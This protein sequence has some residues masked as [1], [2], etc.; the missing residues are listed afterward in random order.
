ME[1]IKIVEQLVGIK[2]NTTRA[3]LGFWFQ[4]AHALV[5]KTIMSLED[6]SLFFNIRSF[7][8]LTMVQ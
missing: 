3:V 7:E 6:K 1:G 4:N 5:A 8:F 2:T